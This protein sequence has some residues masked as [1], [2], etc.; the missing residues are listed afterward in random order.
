MGGNPFF[1]AAELSY[2]IM[3]QFIAYLIVRF[4][5]P[6][7]MSQDLFF[8]MLCFQ[9]FKAYPNATVDEISEEIFESMSTASELTQSTQVVSPFVSALI[10]S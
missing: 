1:F 4:S 9:F 5:N 10:S 3:L 2:C 6:D 8:R 7:D